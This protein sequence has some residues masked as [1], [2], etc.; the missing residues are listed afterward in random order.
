M[1]KSLIAGLTVFLL[2]APCLGQ[3]RD[4]VIAAAVVP[5]PAAMRDN[6]AVVRL[7]AAGQPETLR[8]GTNGMVCIAD[9]PGDAVFD[10]RCYRD[11]FI[12]VVYRTFQ[13][14]ANVSSPQVGAEIEAGKLKL[15]KEPTAGYRCLGPTTSYD[16]AMHSVTGEGE[17]WESLHFPFRTAKEVGFPDMN[18]VPENLRQTVP[19]VMGSGSYWSHV[20]IEHPPVK[21]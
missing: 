16:P 18:E 11:S 1:L 15:S 7:D 3:S 10:V 8:N 20:M 4:Q 13:L 6:A 5:L 12:H 17:C 14:G 21:K 9:K 19:Y 2:A